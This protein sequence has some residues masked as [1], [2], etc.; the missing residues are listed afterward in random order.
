[1]TSHPDSL[2]PIS[3]VLLCGGKSTEHA[4]SLRSAH[5]VAKALIATAHNREH[6]ATSLIYIT[7]QGE[8]Y[9]LEDIKLFL[10]QGIEPLM[11]AKQMPRILLDLGKPSRLY[12]KSGDR[13]W[14]VDCFFPLV[15]GTHGEDGHL[16][17]L[18][19]LCDTAYV[20]SGVLGSAMCM[21]KD[22]TKQLLQA[23]GIM[24]TP[25][26]TVTMTTPLTGLYARLAQKWN[27]KKL[28]IKPAT[29]GSSVGLGQAENESECLAAI[30]T[31]F[32]YDTTV[33][34]EQHIEGREIECAVLGNQ[35][36]TVDP[37]VSMPGEII[38]HTELYTYEAKYLDP[39]A[40]TPVVTPAG[41]S[42]GLIEAIQDISVHTFKILQCS[43]MLRVDFF[44]THTDMLYVNE[45]NTIPGFTES[46]LYHQMMAGVGVNFSD[47]VDRLIQLAMQKHR[48]DDTLQRVYK[49]A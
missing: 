19:E 6:Y 33:L 27:Q 25:W 44:L 20:G 11:S 37:I 32:Q 49:P 17:G 5:N 16:Q 22:I 29:L 39:H 42:P 26:H 10:E 14:N 18:F 8:W 36:R 4:I 13:T 7:E 31:A 38:L 28:I 35:D 2:L 3:I 34:I 15:H 9:Y 47:L 43:G 23:H 30:K 46:S 21:N 12:A 40:A 48:K 41:L 45:T 1:M 24:V